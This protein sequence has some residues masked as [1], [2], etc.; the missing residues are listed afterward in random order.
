VGVIEI[1]ARGDGAPEGLIVPVFSDGGAFDLQPDGCR[2]AGGERS[3][4][5]PE[6][7]RGID[8]LSLFLSSPKARS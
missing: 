5:R 7:R 8:F 3:V 1:E 6:E 4:E 2:P